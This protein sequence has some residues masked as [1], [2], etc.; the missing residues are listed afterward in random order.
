MNVEQLPFDQYSRYN[1]VKEIIQY[2]KKTNKIN[3]SIKILDVGG[4]DFY[5]DGTPWFPLKLFLPDEE[6]LA[7]DI[8]NIELDNYI[9]GDGTD[10]KFN[11]N[12]FDVVISNDVLEHIQEQSRLKF[13]DELIRVSKDLIIM[14]FP[15]SSS[16]NILAEKILYEYI[17]QVTKG[18]NRMLEEHLNN[19]LPDINRIK[20]YINKKKTYY[21]HIFTCNVDL[22]LSM[23]MLRYKLLNILEKK[24]LVKMIDRYFNEYIGQYDFEKSSAY[25]TVFMM[26]KRN[27]SR[28]FIEEIYTEL[29]KRSTKKTMK[30]DVQLPLLITKLVELDKENQNMDRIILHQYNYDDITRRLQKDEEIMQSF[31]CENKNLYKIKLLVATYKQKII[32]TMEFKLKDMQTNKIVVKKELLMEEFKDNEWVTIEFPQI[33]HSDKKEY[34]FSLCVKH[35]KGDN[36]PAFYL[37]K[38]PFKQGRLS[39]NGQETEGHLACQI[40]VKDT[41]RPE[42]YFYE[43]QE[44]DILI[45]KIKRD[46]SDKLEYLKEEF[47]AKLNQLNERNKDYEQQINLLKNINEENKL[48]IKQLKEKITKYESRINQ[49]TGINKEYELKNNELVEIKREHEKIIKKLKERIQDLNTNTSKIKREHKKLLDEY[50]EKLQ[51]IHMYEKKMKTYK[52][53]NENL[54]IL[55]DKLLNEERVLKERLSELLKIL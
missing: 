40:F 2:Y 3:R 39:I 1:L 29:I 49:L 10:I 35:I 44:K 25:R 15:Y 7:L 28:E 4:V 32:G 9:Q 50:N 42:S 16:K 18:E 38:K 26:S 5:E 6:I 36:G 48:N 13:V 41:S 27:E 31:L 43:L 12:E 33:I 37:T 22:W 19:G 24:E 52:L 30:I 45:S 11:N 14:G 54:C 17:L 34:E 20:Q 53:E 23:M 46:F 21:K 51:I 8:Y 55:I 47:E